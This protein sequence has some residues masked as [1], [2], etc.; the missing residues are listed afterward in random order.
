MDYSNFRK[1]LA[2]RGAV[3]NDATTKRIGSVCSDNRASTL[4]DIATGS[5]AGNRKPTSLR[6]MISPPVAPADDGFVHDF[7]GNFS[8]KCA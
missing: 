7:S 6:R 8:R 1:G 5:A 2:A 3:F 4:R